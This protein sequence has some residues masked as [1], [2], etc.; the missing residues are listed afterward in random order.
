MLR[1]MLLEET[2]LAVTP[3][4]AAALVPLWKALQAGGVTA[5]AEVNTIVKQIE[6]EMT[7]AQ[8]EAI[9][10]MQLTQEDMQAWMTEHG[11]SP[12]GGGAPDARAT[13][14]AQGGG[15]GGPPAG[16]EMPPEMATRRAEFENM[17]DEEREAA[18][19]TMEASGGRPGGPGGSGGGGQT[20]G[21]LLGPL[22]ELLEERAG[23]G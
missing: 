6:G 23:E 13:R 4:Q 9:A 22:M 2:E 15:E 18:R 14:Q 16:G 12:P 8:L 19:A 21:F 7:Q 3:E 20:F 1:T 5:E 11:V 17:S 10:A